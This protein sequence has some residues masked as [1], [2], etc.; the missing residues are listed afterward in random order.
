MVPN[1]SQAQRC[2]PWACDRAYRFLRRAYRT[3]IL[4]RNVSYRADPF[5]LLTH[6]TNFPSG[7][8]VGCGWPPEV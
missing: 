4:A 7:D 8:S 5:M 6:M 3:G 2:I 1:V